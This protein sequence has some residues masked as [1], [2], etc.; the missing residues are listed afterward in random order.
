V[1]VS[2]SLLNVSRDKVYISVSLCVSLE[3]ICV[4]LECKIRVS[5]E[6]K[7]GGEGSSPLY[8]ASISF[9]VRSLRPR[10]ETIHNRLQAFLKLLE[11]R[12]IGSA[13]GEGSSPL[14]PTLYILPL[15]KYTS[16]FDIMSSSKDTVMILYVSPL[17]QYRHGYGLY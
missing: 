16:L 2:V 4:S 15:I 9:L 8:P 10:G 1:Y 14:Y 13:C 17:P 3:C 5:L 6:C 7:T 12:I 11:F